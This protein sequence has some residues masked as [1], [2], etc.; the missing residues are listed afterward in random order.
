[1]RQCW[2]LPERVLIVGGYIAVDLATIFHGLGAHVTLLYRGPL[3]LRGFDDDVR[4]VL[5]RE[6]AK[7]GVTLR[8]EARVE[9]IEVSNGVRRAHLAD[10]SALDAELVMFATGRRPNMRRHKGTVR[11]HDR[12]PSDDRRRARRHAAEAMKE[13]NQCPRRGHSTTIKV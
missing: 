5:A 13:N 10:G 11:C 12:H 8:F 6:M 9:R 1:M 2:C 3:F 7:R 4:N